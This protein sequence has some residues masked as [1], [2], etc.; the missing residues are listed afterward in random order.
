MLVRVFANGMGSFTVNQFCESIV[1][2]RDTQLFGIVNSCNRLLLLNK[3]CEEWIVVCGK[4]GVSGIEPTVNVA[5]KD[6]L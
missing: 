5:P 3:A 6:K 4:C 1:C 2:M